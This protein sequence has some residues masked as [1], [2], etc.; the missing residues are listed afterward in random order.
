[1]SK[2]LRQ[3]EK[4]QKRDFLIGMMEQAKPKTITGLKSSVNKTKNQLEKNK[5]KL[6]KMPEEEFRKRISRDI[7]GVASKPFYVDRI[8]KNIQRLDSVVGR[9]EYLVEKRCAGSTITDYMEKETFKGRMNEGVSLLDE[10]TPKKCKCISDF[11]KKNK[12]KYRE[13][14]GY[15]LIGGK[16]EKQ[17]HRDAMKACN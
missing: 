11:V 16:K 15:M 1:M 6:L 8:D 7:F 4:E 10:F 3:I 14:D 5:E 2:S 12:D 13:P 9:V 17:M